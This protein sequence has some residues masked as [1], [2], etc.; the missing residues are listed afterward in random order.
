MLYDEWMKVE[1]VEKSHELFIFSIKR[2]KSF[3]FS[4]ISSS[5]TNNIIFCH[6]LFYY[7]GH[8][9]KSSSHFWYG[10]TEILIKHGDF[11][12][13]WYSGQKSNL[14]RFLYNFWGDRK[15]MTCETFFE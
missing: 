9:V 11:R 4:F 2:E 8:K 1:W 10:H 13:I 7:Y 15:A 6:L 12:K 14:I 3:D 5:L